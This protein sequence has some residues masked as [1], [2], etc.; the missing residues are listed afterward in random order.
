MLTTDEMHHEAKLSKF[1]NRRTQHVY[2][3]MFKQKIIRSFLMIEISG[4]ELM[5]QYC[6]LLYYRDVKNS[7]VTFSIMEH[8]FGT[9]YPYLRE[10]LKN[11][12]TSKM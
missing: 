6:I 3:C 8:D 4:Q 7:S 2:N 1:C 9:S 10:G 12:P 5:M 11:I